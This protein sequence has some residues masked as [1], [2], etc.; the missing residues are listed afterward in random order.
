[1]AISMTGYG[2]GEFLNDKYHINVESKSVNNRYLDINIKM[3][4]NISYL[5][6]FV[7]QNL[8]KYISRGKVDIFIKFEIYNQND[9]KVTYDKNIAREYFNVLSLIE[10]DFEVRNNISTVDIAKFPDVLK[11]E[12]SEIDEEEFKELF[13][14]ALDQSFSKLKEMREYEGKELEKDILLRTKLLSEYIE[15]IEKFS[16]GIEEEQ[17]ERLYTKI[18]DIFE[19]FDYNIDEPRI[20]Q[21]AAIL[22]DKSNIDE[23]ITRFKAHI[24][25]LE[26]SVL[27]KNNG[28][29]MDFIIQEMN[30]EINT[31]GSKS[32][33]LDITNFVVDIKSELE[34][35]REQ[36]QNI[37]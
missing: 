24:K 26:E 13:S 16:Q 3:P 21:E 4:R 33:K 7:K 35:I 12:D 20:I 5:E 17:R 29:K 19:K 18:K 32:S 27:S 6:E 15:N 23:E 8:R 31:V 2:K 1:M 14:I 25:Q 28:R 9:V 11:V 22:V 10:S 36:V 37:E 30:R 34:K